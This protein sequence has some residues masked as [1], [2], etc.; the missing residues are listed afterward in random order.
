MV[1]YGDDSDNK[2]ALKL[3]CMVERYGSY[4]MFAALRDGKFLDIKNTTTLV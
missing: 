2:L 3:A 1:I 4:S